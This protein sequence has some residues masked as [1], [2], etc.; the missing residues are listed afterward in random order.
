MTHLMSSIWIMPDRFMNG[1]HANDQI[2]MRGNYT[3]DSEIVFGSPTWRRSLENE[4]HLDYLEDL[5]IPVWL[6]PVLKMMRTEQSYHG[7]F[8]TDLYRIDRRLGTNDDYVRLIDKVHG[9]GMRVV[10]DMIF[11]HIGPKTSMGD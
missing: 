2:P 3:V 7:Y 8:A 9:K 5:G 4:Q 1:D 10:M 6:N 11:N